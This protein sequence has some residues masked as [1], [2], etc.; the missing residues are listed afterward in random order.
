MKYEEISIGM[1]A[2]FSIKT[3]KQ[4]TDEFAKISGDFNPL[5]CDESYAETTKFEK[6]VVHGLFLASLISKLIGMHLPG[7]NSLILSQ[8][9]R[10]IVP[11]FVGDE[12]SVMGKVIHKSDSGQT[13]TLETRIQRID[14]ETLLTGKAKVMVLDNREKKVEGGSKQEIPLTKKRVLITGGSGGIGSSI[15]KILTE[16]GAEVLITYNKNKSNAENLERE[17]LENKGSCSIH[18]LDLLNQDSVD[19]F[20]NEISSKGFID[21]FIHCSSGKAEPLSFETQDWTTFQEN[22][23]IT[24]KGFFQITKKLLPNMIQNKR[25]NILSILST[26]IM[27]APQ[28]KFSSY[29]MAKSGLLGLTKSLA[30]EYGGNGIRFNML[31]PGLTD[32]NLLSSVPKRVIEYAAFQTPLKR[33]AVPSDI[34][35]VALFLVSDLSDY[36]SGVNIPVCGGHDMM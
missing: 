1:E 33:I 19:S 4:L 8:E 17:L 23:D 22:I 9:T 12:I 16:N 20:F 29:V 10:F 31:S 36:L 28:D 32:T 15:A 3:S 25:G 27:G 35:K 14:G 6:R 2:S 7:K 13:I 5:H 30:I 24:L 34:A 26:F 21:T 11:C 18:H